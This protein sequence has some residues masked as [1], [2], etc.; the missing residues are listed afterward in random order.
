M[1]EVWER[2][3]KGELIPQKGEITLEDKHLRIAIEKQRLELQKLESE[4]DDEKREKNKVVRNRV[5]S[6]LEES[7]AEREKKIEFLYTPLLHYELMNIK[8]GL[9]HDGTEVEDVEAY[10]CSRHCKSPLRTYEEWKNMKEFNE[11]LSIARFIYTNSIPKRKVTE[12]EEEAFQ[13]LQE[14]V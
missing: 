9:A 2:N 4:K 12:K 10:L 5:I 1:I 6:L 14:L 8:Q 3:E 7:L 11:K 13:M